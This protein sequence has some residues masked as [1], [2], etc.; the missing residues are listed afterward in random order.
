LIYDIKDPVIKEFLSSLGRK[1]R[2]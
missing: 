1:S 2:L